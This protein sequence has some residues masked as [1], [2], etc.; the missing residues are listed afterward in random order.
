M[1]L[2]LRLTK[3]RLSTISGA[4]QAFLLYEHNG[5][6]IVR[7]T[8][9]LEAFVLKLNISEDLGCCAARSGNLWRDDSPR[10]VP[11]P[12]TPHTLRL[13]LQPKDP[14]WSSNLQSVLRGM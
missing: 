7:E 12:R 10:L 6:R 2:V 13:C 9:A 8:V 4:I 11:L 1:L 14:L 3:Y 5:L